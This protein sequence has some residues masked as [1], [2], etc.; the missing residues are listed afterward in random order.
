M[1]VF[2]SSACQHVGTPVGKF[3]QILLVGPHWITV[4]NIHCYAA[5]V[6]VYDS[7]YRKTPKLHQKKFQTQVAHKYLVRHATC[8][9][10]TYKI[11]KEIKTVVWVCSPLS[12]HS[13]YADVLNRR[14]ARGTKHKCGLTSSNAST[15]IPY[16]CCQLCTQIRQDTTDEW[17]T[18]NLYQYSAAADNPL[19]EDWPWPNVKTATSGTTETANQCHGQLRRRHALFVSAAARSNQY[20]LRES[21]LVAFHMLYHAAR[22][23]TYILNELYD[24]S[25]Q[26]ILIM[27]GVIVAVYN[28]FSRY[29]LCIR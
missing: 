7:I 10:T 25:W 29:F 3:V 1:S 2:E 16:R 14:T 15:V 22:L 20:M 21:G 26:N 18:A 4:S 24:I 6:D 9:G 8:G 11:K 5:S 12:I 19:I 28:R 17:L 13:H 27:Y 23:Y